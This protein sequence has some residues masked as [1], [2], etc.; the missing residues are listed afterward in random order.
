[1]NVLLIN[2][3]NLNMLGLRDHSLYGTMNTDD[4]VKEI[5]AQSIELGVHLDYHQSN[6]EGALVDH[7][8]SVTPSSDGIIINPGALT[9]YGLSLRD[10]L[11][12]ARLPVIEVHISNIHS[13]EE[14]RRRSV[15]TSLSLGQIAGLGWKGYI[16]ALEAMVEHLNS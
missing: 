7:I 16:Y 8:Q 3:P 15:I 13:R 12:D 9:H 5:R 2:G 6:D 11:L 1:M 10:A 4:I 14:Y